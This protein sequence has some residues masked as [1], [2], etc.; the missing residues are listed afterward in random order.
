MSSSH[1]SPNLKGP[2]AILVALLLPH[3]LTQPHPEWYFHAAGLISVAGLLL[4]PRH[5]ACAQVIPLLYL[6]WFQSLSQV[7][8]PP[9][10][11]VADLTPS[12]NTI[13]LPVSTIEDG[14]ISIPTLPVSLQTQ[15]SL[16]LP[17][18]L[19]ALNV[20]LVPGSVMAM[21]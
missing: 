16:L 19:P 8:E 5:C 4:P 7:Q 10:V 9:I 12:P 3:L 6:L 1:L 21:L 13:G 14:K 15:A 11:F 2:P 17:S 20:L 18:F